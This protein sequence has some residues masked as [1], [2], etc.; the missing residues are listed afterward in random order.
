MSP[1]S[2]PHLYAESSG[3]ALDFSDP[4]PWL[5]GGGILLVCCSGII[6][7][8]ILPLALSARNKKQKQAAQS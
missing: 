6:L 2:D 1:D 4:V 3:L 7:A 5:V 8:I